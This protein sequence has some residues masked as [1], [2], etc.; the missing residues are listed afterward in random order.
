VSAAMMLDIGT[1]V[2]LAHA[3]TAHV[4]GEIGV[5]SLCVKG[6]VLSEQELRA[7]RVSSDADVLVDPARIDDLVSA[8]RRRGW[9]ERFVA[10]VPRILGNHAVT[11]FHPE[12][13]CD[14]DV[15]HG[16]LGFLAPE[17]DVFETIWSRRGS[18]LI[19][20]TEVVCA[21]PIANSAMLA[22]HCLR[23]M[24]VARNRAEL[25]GLVAEWTG[26]RQELD[27]AD[28]LDFARATGSIETLRPFLEQIDID[29]P[30]APPESPALAAW[31]LHTSSVAAGRAAAWLAA[32]TTA[33]WRER[34]RILSRA[35]L[36]PAG[37]YRLEH[38]EIG[39]RRRDFATAIVRRT[40]NGARTLP[41]AAVQIA[42]ARRL[43]A[44]ARTAGG[45]SSAVRPSAHT[46]HSPSTPSRGGD[47]MSKSV[48]IIGTR[49]YP[50]YYGGFETAVRRLAPYLA[51]RGWDVTVYGR[52]GSTKDD[53]AAR[54]RRVRTR[55]TRGIES[56]SL[57][58][59]TYGLTACV[60]AVRR[61]PDVALVMN[62]ANGF[63]LPLLRGRGIPTAVNVD[64][65]E[66]DRAKWG[67][68]AKNVFRS[69]AKATALFGDEL[70][71]DAVEISRRWKKDFQ[72]DGTFIPY[73]GDDPGPLPEVEGFPHRGYV[74]I[75][76]RFVPE[77]TVPEFL[78][79]AATLGKTWPVV[80]VGSSGYGGE[81]DERAEKLAASEEKVTW[82]GH[83]SD[84]R[85]LFALW[86][87]AGAYFHGH[88]VGGTNPALVQ[89]MSCGAPTVARDTVYNREVLAESGVFVAPEPTAIAAAVDAL[90]RDPNAQEQLGAAAHAR[91]RSTYSWEV[92]CEAYEAALEN[93]VQARTVRR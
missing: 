23:E 71:Y 87:H 15:H 45:L 79:A 63:W 19:A 57:S 24:H 91:G 2:Q 85:K 80:I 4:S 48:A 9:E 46:T 27:P 53:D 52:D 88:S 11:L 14:I 70:I 89:A 20:G 72:R 93:L 51:E 78:E 13:P 42:R 10:D 64:G 73:G 76:A 5:R 90:M 18:T 66:W 55:V 17:K 39:P 67:K 47:S 12:W 86:Q 25:A 56:K 92:V 49:G 35:V 6:P 74:L 60:D 59:L 41:P 21:D 28:L 65:I 81:L 84:D 68:L 61:K 3:L 43:L 77:N 31:N 38:P 29:A 62:V 37:E 30:A 50:S 33:P 8:L 36:P 32:V 40:V 34:P 1:A 54:D 16:F 69:G 58:T 22:L 82:L 7:P 26:G 83:V 75:V 44:S